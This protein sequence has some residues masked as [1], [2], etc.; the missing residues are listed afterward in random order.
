MGNST[1]GSPSKDETV[2][3]QAAA[4]TLRRSPVR[5][6]KT[7]A[8]PIKTNVL[9]GATIL[10]VYDLID[11]AMKPLLRRHS[12]WKIRLCNWQRGYVLHI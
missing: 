1:A 6:C 2:A 4:G 12:P 8:T 5:E 7:R 9:I 3:A 11:L 10:L